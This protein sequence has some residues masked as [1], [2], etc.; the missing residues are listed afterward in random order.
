MEQYANSDNPFIL[1][2]ISGIRNK[3]Y[4]ERND[5]YITHNVIIITEN[6]WQKEKIPTEE[7][8]RDSFNKFCRLNPKF[9]KY[10]KF[11]KAQQL[12]YY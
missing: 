8:A 3:M 4:H 2:W 11:S 12:K 6:T 1:A 7:M 5:E 9:I 10:Y